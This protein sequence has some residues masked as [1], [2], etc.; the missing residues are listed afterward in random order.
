MEIG[1]SNALG[2]GLVI[3]ICLA[4]AIFVMIVFARWARR[5]SKGALVTGAILSAFA[6]DP[7][8]EKNIRLVEEARK[9]QSEEDEEGQGKDA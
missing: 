7:T 2:T 6:P 1:F 3:T 5:R 8:F 9:V 4:A